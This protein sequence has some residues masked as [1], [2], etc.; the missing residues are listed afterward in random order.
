[1]KNVLLQDFG[2]RR[3]IRLLSNGIRV[4]LFRKANSPIFIRAVFSAG[5]RFD[6]EGKDGLAHFAEHMLVAGT[7]KY[8]T[9]DKLATY[10]EKY[11]G[12][13]G[14][15][16]ATESMNI[17][18]EVAESLDIEH[19]IEVLSQIL[20]ESLY[21]P[22]VIET[23]RKSILRE[24]GEWKSSPRNFISEVAEKLCF[25]ETEVGR[26]VLGSASTL[27]AITRHDFLKY[28]EEVL[29]SKKMA[30]VAC[31]DIDIDRLTEKLEGRLKVTNN[32]VLEKDGHLPLI[33]KSYQ[34]IE[35]YPH[36]EEVQFDLGFRTTSYFDQDTPVLRLIAT[37]LAGGRAATLTKRLRQDKGLVYSVFGL[38]NG[39]RDSGSWS[40]RSST[41]R[42]DLQ[43]T[44]N[45]ICE[46]IGR[47]REDGLTVEE[48]EFA[49]N[50]TIKSTKRG[51]QTSES[52]VAFHSFGELLKPDSY[53]TLDK[54]LER[55][56]NIQE[57]EVRDVAKKYFK[58]DAW[59]LSMCGDV[60]EDEVKVNL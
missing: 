48:I 19:A 32:A 23:E 20:S 52:W 54:Y 60:E 35:T 30:I 5:S 25:Q 11:G 15:F 56:S 53:L 13:H 55:I 42:K 45:I 8:P 21:D 51:M 31:G 9:K 47:V 29:N 2:V 24:L 3:E 17:K 14:G 39:L 4:I 40:I 7:R 27:A 49:K 57:S 43:E 41:S 50:K 33:R 16:T 36:L 58:N 37:V 59:F 38:V 46:E 10:I 6:P 12:V 34:R 18:V 1:M 22:K 28:Q 44:I 26:S